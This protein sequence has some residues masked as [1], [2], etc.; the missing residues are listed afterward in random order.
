MTTEPLKLSIEDKVQLNTAYSIHLR[1]S[2]DDKMDF[3]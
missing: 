1:P 2:T 3:T